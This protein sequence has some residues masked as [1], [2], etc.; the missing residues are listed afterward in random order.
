MN[1]LIYQKYPQTSTENTNNYPFRLLASTSSPFPNQTTPQALGQSLNGGGGW[2][3]RW[4]KRRIISSLTRGRHVHSPSNP[5]PGRLFSGDHHH[6]IL[7]DCSGQ[8]SPDRN[9]ARMSFSSE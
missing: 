2:R 5:Y 9:G 1:I 3:W 4:R 7:G 8:R 6:V